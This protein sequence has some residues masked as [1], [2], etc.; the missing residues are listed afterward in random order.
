MA[1]LDIMA[2]G[3]DWVIPFLQRWFGYCLTAKMSHQHFLFLQELP[4]TGKS[5]L[6]TIMLVLMGTY[7]TTL[8]GVW[9]M[10]NS[11]KRFDMVTIIGKHLG[12]ADETQ[13]SATFDE[14]RIAT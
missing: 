2:N 12:V 14:E 4:G 11:D 7:G 5:Q 8:R 1:F 6:I 9:M 10:K 3:R 13:K